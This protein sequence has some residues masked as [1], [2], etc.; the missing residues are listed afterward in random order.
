MTHD[1]PA[2]ET[3]RF[4]L[5]APEMRDFE[6][7]ATMWSDERVTR[8]IGAGARSR[9]ESWS[10]FL[11]MSGA[12]AL[13]DYGFWVFADRADDRF[14]G[15]G[16]MFWADRGVAQLVGYPEAGWS[17]APDW[18]GKGVA[19]EVM[20]AALDW[21]DSAL[22]AAEVRCII[23]PGHIVSERVAAKLGFHLIGEAEMAPDMVN[24]YARPRWGR[25]LRE[26]AVD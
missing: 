5:R 1:I 26:R 3:Q 13:M 11:S 17:V 20:T 6:A 12:W 8:F 18:W 7:Y 22:E 9:T 16:G 25:G 24:V 15:S 14:I 19:S 2:I 21:A 23:N 4:R 10:K